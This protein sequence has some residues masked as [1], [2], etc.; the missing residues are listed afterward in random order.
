M[1]GCFSSGITIDWVAYQPWKFIS[2]SSGCWESRLLCQHGQV[3]MRTASQGCRWLTSHCTLLWWRGRR[4]GG[5][6][7][8]DSNSIQEGFILRASSNP[9]YLLITI[10]LGLPRW[11]S[12]KESA[13]QCRRHKRLGFSPC[14][15]KIPWSRKWQLTLV[16]LPGKFHGHRSL[17]G[18]SP[19]S[20]KRVRTHTHTYSTHLGVWFQ[21]TDFRE[22]QNTHSLTIVERHYEF[23]K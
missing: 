7:S 5:K 8:C 20:H 16:F 21:Q 23:K 12:S 4:R 19:W 3:P 6:F 13:C 2:H 14:V 17:V 1:H 10:T 9:N 22:T 15:G 11:H 18:Y